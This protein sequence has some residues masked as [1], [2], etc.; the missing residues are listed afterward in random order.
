MHV[1]PI[2]REHGEDIEGSA[3]VTPVSN[4]ISTA[5]NYPTDLSSE[6]ATALSEAFRK[7]PLPHQIPSQCLMPLVV[8]PYRDGVGQVPIRTRGP[9][10]WPTPSSVDR[11]SSPAWNCAITIRITL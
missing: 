3:D 5:K 7:V 2:Y 11:E 6:E 4:V 9:D 1:H 10:F 8:R